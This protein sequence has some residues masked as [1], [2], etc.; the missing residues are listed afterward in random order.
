LLPERNGEAVEEAV[1]IRHPDAAIPECV[2]P[3]RKPLTFH[4]FVLAKSE[5]RKGE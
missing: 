1:A 4:S 5:E 3:S 2:K